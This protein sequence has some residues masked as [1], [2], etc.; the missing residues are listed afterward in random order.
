M[1]FPVMNGAVTTFLGVICLG[2]GRSEIFRIFFRMF[3]LIIIFS[4]FFG[5]MVLPVFLSVVGPRPLATIEELE[6]DTG[7]QGTTEKQAGKV[8]M[9]S[10]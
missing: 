6:E 10:V 4:T 2:L 5:L 1:A 7:K 8:E 9:A 3:F